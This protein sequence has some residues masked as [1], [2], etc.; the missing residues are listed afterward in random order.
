MKKTSSAKSTEVEEDLLN[1][2]EVDTE[3]EETFLLTSKENSGDSSDDNNLSNNIED[4]CVQVTDHQNK[5]E[6]QEQE[7]VVKILMSQCCDNQC[8]LFLTGYDVL[9]ARNKVCFLSVTSQRQMA[10]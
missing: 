4:L 3:A 5:E 10:H 2:S 1:D 9:S 6:E 7:I 8:L